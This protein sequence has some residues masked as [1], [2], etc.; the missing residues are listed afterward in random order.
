MVDKNLNPVLQCK[1]KLLFPLT[2]SAPF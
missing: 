1:S 2:L